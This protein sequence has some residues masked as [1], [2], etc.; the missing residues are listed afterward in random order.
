MTTEIQAHAD[1]MAETEVP[2]QPVRT[3]APPP[4]AGFRPL[5]E[6]QIGAMNR[7]KVLEEVVLRVV[8]TM[9]DS[10][11]VDGRMLALGVTNLQQAFHWFNRSIAQPARINGD[12]TSVLMRCLGI[13]EQDKPE[14]KDK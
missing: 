3:F 14:T 11:A 10:D 6:H 5:D 8:D 2:A 13:P 7:F 9:R 1:A 12:I 4:I